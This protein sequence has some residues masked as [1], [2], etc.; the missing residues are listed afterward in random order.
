M[1]E[2][3]A[4]A[5]R[6]RRI[7]RRPIAGEARQRDVVAAQ[8]AEEQRG[9]LAAMPGR[10]DTAR[11]RRTS[12]WPGQ[13][14]ARAREHE[15]VDR[16][17]RPRRLERPEQGRGEQHVP[18]PP[19][20]DHQHARGR[21]LRRRACDRLRLTRAT[22]APPPAAHAA[23]YPRR[24]DRSCRRRRIP[25]HGRAASTTAGSS[26]RTSGRARARPP[27]RSA[28]GGA[29]ASRHCATNRPAKQHESGDAELHDHQQDLVVRI[30]RGRR[31]GA[32]DAVRVR[33]AEAAGADPSTGLAP[34]ISSVFCRNSRRR[35]TDDVG[36]G[37]TPARHCAN[38]SS[39]SVIRRAACCPGEASTIAASAAS[40]TP[41]SASPLAPRTRP[42]K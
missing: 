20:D 6:E 16:R 25:R 21:C 22:V 37:G 18:H 27:D 15:H 35:P 39:A 4:P 3:G 32:V 10:S 28:S 31:T 40:T 9:V 26:P 13:H 29:R 42:R 11:T 41:A 24:G 33:L 8:Q 30:L 23:R 19:G 14:V 12:G 1:H 34:M 38:S 2:P 36:S 7:E 17:L 5:A